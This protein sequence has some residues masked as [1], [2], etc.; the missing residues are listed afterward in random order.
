MKAKKLIALLLCALLVLSLV[1]CKKDDTKTDTPVDGIEDTSGQEDQKEDTK[2][3]DQAQKED[4]KKDEPAVEVQE[5]SIDFEDGLYG[6]VAIYTAPPNA[7]ASELSIA[8]FNGSKA[9]KVTNMNGKYPLCC[10]RHC[11]L[12]GT[13]LRNQDSHGC[14]VEHPDGKFHA[15]S[16]N[17]YLTAVKRKESNDP[18]SVY[19]LQGTNTAKAVLDR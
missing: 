16:G 6:F 12:A 1:G 3:D 15:I 14:S 8:D 9:L 4:G 19:A 18:F 11:K 13:R 7:D 10:Y 5:A 17:I 2:S